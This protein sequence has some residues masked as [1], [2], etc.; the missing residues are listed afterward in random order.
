MKQGIHPNHINI[1]QE[2]RQLVN[3]KYLKETIATE[4]NKYDLMPDALQLI[5]QIESFFKVQK[6]KT[7]NQVLG[8]NYQD[9]ILK[10]LEIFPK[11]KLPSG[12]QARSDKKNI[13]VAFKWFFETYEYSWDIILKATLNYVTDY[14]SRSYKFM[15]TSQY[16]IRK[17]NSDKTW[18]SELA[19]MCS[20]I[21][22]GDTEEPF[23]FTGNVY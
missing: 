4:G 22:S 18:A 5:E 20:Q 6:K 23:F 11:G 9:E 1:H 8:T 19:N 12:K 14:E 10:Y 15:Q 17:Q 13:E 7:N 3:K 16:F 21:E 2:L